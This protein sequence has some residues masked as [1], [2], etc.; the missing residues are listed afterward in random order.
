[1][2]EG[3]AER[4]RAFATEQ[5]GGAQRM[6]CDAISGELAVKAESLSGDSPVQGG[7]LALAAWKI[8]PHR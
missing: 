7:L 5:T 1:V 4:Q 3:M 2:E 8:S 6:V